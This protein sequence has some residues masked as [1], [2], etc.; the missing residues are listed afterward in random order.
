M[1][2]YVRIQACMKRR[3]ESRNTAGAEGLKC[4]DAEA[5]P[6]LSLPPVKFVALWASQ[7]GCW[8]FQSVGMSRFVVVKRCLLTVLLFGE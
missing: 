8:A 3:E 4:G 2:Q 5:G 1:L 6:H 7:S